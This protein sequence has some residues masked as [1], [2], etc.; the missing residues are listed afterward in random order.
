MIL[1][2]G[3]V[4]VTVVY[5]AMPLQKKKNVD[6]KYKNESTRVVPLIW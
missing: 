4:T 2:L 6:L 5:Q 3:N 1:P